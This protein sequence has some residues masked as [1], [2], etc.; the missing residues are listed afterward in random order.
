[1]Y[2]TGDYKHVRVK[3]FQTEITYSLRNQYRVVAK[4]LWEMS[5]QPDLLL[6]QPL[7]KLGAVA[8]SWVQ[9][10]KTKENTLNR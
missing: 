5:Y 10:A 7:L 8:I 4:F 6:A 3:T 1:M 9:K 2:Y